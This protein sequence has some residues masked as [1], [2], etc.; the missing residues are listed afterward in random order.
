MGLVCRFRKALNE[1]GAW[2]VLLQQINTQLSRHGI[3]VKHGAHHQ[4]PV[5]PTLRHP[6]GKTSDTLEL[7]E[8]ESMQRSL[9][10]GVDQETRRVKKGGNCSRATSAI[11]SLSLRR[12]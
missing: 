6:Q 5:T 12:A 3:L 11:A 10:A 1:S 7:E 8:Q 9:Q 2:E 4:Y